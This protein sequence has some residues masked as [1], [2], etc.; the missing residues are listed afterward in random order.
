MKREGGLRVAFQVAA[1]TRPTP[2]AEMTRENARKPFPFPAR[3]GIPHDSTAE[4]TSIRRS[5]PGGRAQLFEQR[6]ISGILPEAV[7]LAHE[8]RSC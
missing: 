4:V 7:N 2:E 6:K 5:L 1:E 8:S 3:I